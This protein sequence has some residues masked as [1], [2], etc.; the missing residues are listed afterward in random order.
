VTRIV[1]ICLVATLVGCGGKTAGSTLPVVAST[2]VYGDIARQIGGSRVSV[3]SVLSDPN[4]DP[5]LFEPGTANGL[6]VSRARVVIQNGLDYDSFMSRLER[7]APSDNRTVVTI[8]DVLGI[9]GQD[10]NPHLWYDVPALPKVAAAIEQA[11][12]E[13]DAAHASKYQSGLRRFIASLAPLQATVA[14]IRATHAGAPV[15]YT[16]P[17]PG[18]LIEAAGLRDFSLSSFTHPIEEGSEPSA[19]AVSAMTSLATQHRIKVLL[20]NNQAVSP[21]T[22]RVNAAAKA[23]GIPV[24]GVAETLPAGLTFQA[25]QLEQV[26]ALLQALGG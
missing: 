21:I 17:V 26:R 10:A 24:V 13:A 25:W 14:K 18:Y 23:A 6:A 9:H 1:L 12:A 5:H 11:L 22:K 16:E 2:N 15:A 7:S 3:T 19:S 20:Y 8:G 4:A